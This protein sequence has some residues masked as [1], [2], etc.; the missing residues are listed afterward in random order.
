ML[1]IS[2]S[3][4]VSLCNIVVLFWQM[5]GLGATTTI[6]IFLF[7]DSN[8]VFENKVSAASMCS[9]LQKRTLCCFFYTAL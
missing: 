9:L 6:K 8:N 7:L 2:L 5:K 1:M 3:H 4:Y